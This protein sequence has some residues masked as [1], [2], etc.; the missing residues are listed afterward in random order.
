MTPI[1]AHGYGA[2]SESLDAYWMPFTA[3]REFKANPRM[4]VAAE[5]CHYI[6]ADGRRI[7]DSLSGLWCCGAGHRRAEIVAAVSRQI[8]ELDFAPPFQFGHP[9]AFA[10]ANK[11]AAMTPAGLDRVFFTNSGS[12]AADTSLKMARA[13]WRLKGRASKTKIIGRAK[14]YHGVN[15]GGISAGGIGPNRKLFGGLLDVDHLPHTLF[16]RLAGSGGGTGRPSG[17]IGRAARRLQH[18]RR[19]C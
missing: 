5:G 16:A 19:D 15:F 3:N 10:L 18:R 12:E 6:D 9:A 13:Y 14:G 7:F 17:R 4:I 8:A 1:S 2:G 11:L